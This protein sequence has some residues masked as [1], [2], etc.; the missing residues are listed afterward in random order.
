MD[1]LV[2]NITKYIPYHPGGK[3]KIMLGAGRDATITFHRFHK[4][5]DPSK[6]KLS[7]LCIGRLCKEGEAMNYVP[8]NPNA[9][10]L[11]DSLMF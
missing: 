10:N 4:G 3:K 8:P 5:F 11:L 9:L 2:Y 7:K 1:D 6:T